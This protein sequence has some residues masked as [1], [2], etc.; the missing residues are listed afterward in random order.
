MYARHQA[1]KKIPYHLIYLVAAGCRVLLPH[2]QRGR[3]QKRLRQAGLAHLVCAAYRFL[4]SFQT[5]NAKTKLF[6]CT[7]QI[8]V[9]SLRLQSYSVSHIKHNTLL[10]EHMIFDVFQTKQSVKL[11]PIGYLHKIIVRPDFSFLRTN[12]ER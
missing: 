1:A 6:C 2:P 7:I 10:V 9:L 4:R 12:K 8:N 11:N 5:K 3:R